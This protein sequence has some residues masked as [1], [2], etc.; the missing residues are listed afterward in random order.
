MSSKLVS[1]LHPPPGCHLSLTSKWVGE[2]EK[3]VRALFKAA[4]ERAPSII[5]IDE[6]CSRRERRVLTSPPCELPSQIRPRPLTPLPPHAHPFIAVQ[7]DSILSSRS[8]GEND[9]MRRLKTE[10]L[11][12]VGTRQVQVSV[13][14]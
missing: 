9:A 7:I 4:S 8:S 14:V 12:Q 13:Q 3:L 6:V 1:P 11:V 5:F 10:F 2:G